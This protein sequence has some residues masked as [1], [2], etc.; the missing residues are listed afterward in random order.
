MKKYWKV[1]SNVTLAALIMTAC[2]TSDSN[3]KEVVGG[4][5]DTGYEQPTDVVSLEE[6]AIAVELVAKENE[7]MKYEFK[8]TNTTDKEI[9]LTF[10]SL[11]EYDFIIKAQDGTKLFQYSEEMM[12]GE[13]LVEKTMAPGETLTMDVDLTEVISMLESGMY[14][15][16]IWSSARESDGLRT[17]INITNS[18]DSKPGVI[19]EIVLFV[20][21]VDNN[22]IEVKDEAGNVKVFQISEEVKTYINNIGEDD[23]ISINYYEGPYDQ[24]VITSI[25][26]C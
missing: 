8:L 12:F 17:E 13:A 25:E 4:S 20:G 7:E 21:L 6:D 26:T 18:N 1:L 24:L 5:P 10:A 9:K 3:E 19:T 23:Q 2:G 22:S 14:T 15:L 16:E 11:Q